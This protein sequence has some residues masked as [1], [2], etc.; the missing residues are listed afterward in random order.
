M[1][2]MVNST[3]RAS[4]S[5]TFGSLI[6]DFFRIKG[7]DGKVFFGASLGGESCKVCPVLEDGTVSDQPAKENFYKWEIID[8]I[9]PEL[10]GISKPSS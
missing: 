7:G 3:V 1:N 4:K 6:S 9:A 8:I 5:I 2:Q 10:L